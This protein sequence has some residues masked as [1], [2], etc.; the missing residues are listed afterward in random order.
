MTS[1]R[2][3]LIHLLLHMGEGCVF[4][5]LIVLLNRLLFRMDQDYQQISVSAMLGETPVTKCS[6]KAEDAAAPISS[7][8][9]I[10]NASCLKL[11]VS[12]ARISE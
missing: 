9:R 4:H 6:P 5:T 7:S 12:D 2:A 11:C 3:F 1:L 8:L 10:E